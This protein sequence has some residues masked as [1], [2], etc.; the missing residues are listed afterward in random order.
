MSRTCAFM[1]E[2]QHDKIGTIIFGVCV[3][4]CVYACVC[5]S[6]RN[7]PLRNFIPTSFQ[8]NAQGWPTVHIYYPILDQTNNR[9]NEEFLN[10]KDIFNILLIFKPYFF[11]FS[12]GAIFSLFL[13]LPTSH[14]LFISLLSSRLFSFVCQWCFINF[15]VITFAE[16][17]P[18][19]MA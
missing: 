4:I 19:G 7:A 18:F 6:V 5:R 9:N 15:Q 11:F 17:K 1:I 2:G 10:L 13:C 16:C 14:L 12:K 8:C 3:C